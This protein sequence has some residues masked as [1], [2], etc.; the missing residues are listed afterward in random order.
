MSLPSLPFLPF[1]KPTIDEAT[2]AAVGEVLRSGWITSGPKVQAFEKALS[3][4]LGGRIVRTFNSGTCTMEIALRI[5]G[6]GPGDEVITTPISWVATANVILE[7]GATPVFADIDPI[8]RNIDLDRLEAAITPRTKAIIPVYLSGLPVDMDRLYAIAAKHKLRVVE[9]A[10]QALGST[11]NGKRIG[12]FGDFVS[13]SLQANK[14]ITSAEGGFL[15]LNNADEARLA[16]KYRLQGVTRSGFDGLEVDVL[17]GK[18]NLTDVNAAIGLGQFAHIDAVTAHRKELARHYFAC[19][20][21]NFEANYGAQLPVAD[22]ENS[23]WHMFQLVLPERITR[24]AFMEKMME[25]QVGIG[26][27]YP[28]IHLLKLYRERGFKEGMFPVAERVGQRIV[29]LPMFNVMRKEDV[30]RAVETVKS[31]L[32]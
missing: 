15:V 9:D 6:I 20:G 16:E 27:H 23:N 2:I 10:A 17:G 14:N 12:S 4:Y 30:V 28:A 24:A 5:A 1:A 13:F 21:S 31:V 18:Y 3:E 8:T 29:S 25:K 19:F 32:G 7:T 26:Y 22:F 11:W